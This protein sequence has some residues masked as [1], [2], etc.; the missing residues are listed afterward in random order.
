M[1]LPRLFV[2]EYGVRPWVAIL[3]AALAV[4]AVCTAGWA[5]VTR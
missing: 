2:D 1:R 5:V 4:I 3:A